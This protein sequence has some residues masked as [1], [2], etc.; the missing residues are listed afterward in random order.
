MSDQSQLC[1]LVALAISVA[2]LV[3]GFILLL[4][5]KMRHEMSDS[6]VLQ[7]Q[8][9]GFGFILLSQVILILGIGLCANMYGGL[10]I[11]QKAVLRQE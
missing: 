6:E 11:L 1:Y 8:L 10:G 2:L 4:R 9:R 3:Y 7:R 5:K